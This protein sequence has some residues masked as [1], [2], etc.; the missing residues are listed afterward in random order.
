MFGVRFFGR[1]CRQ[2][3]QDVVFR[4]DRQRYTDRREIMHSHRQGAV[5]V[6]HPMAYVRQAHAQSLR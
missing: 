1:Q 3:R 4:R 6:E 2:M 5:H